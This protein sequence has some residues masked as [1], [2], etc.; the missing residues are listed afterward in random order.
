M[1]DWRMK[2]RQML[3]WQQRRE[4]SKTSARSW[5]KILMTLKW[6]WPKWKRRSMQQRIRWPR[7][8]GIILPHTVLLYSLSVLWKIVI[9]YEC[10]EQKWDVSN[11]YFHLISWQ[12]FF[13]QGSLWCYHGLF[14]FYGKLTIFL[15][16]LS[17]WSSLFKE[18]DL[19]RIYSC[20][21]SKYMLCRKDIPWARATQRAFVNPNGKNLQRQVK[22]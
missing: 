1:K 2:K 4:N 17:T 5:R 10:S 8:Q 16:M 3:N 12:N 9:T 6:L 7:N 14:Q 22:I 11:A 20:F 15:A 13:C 18:P 21:C 19:L